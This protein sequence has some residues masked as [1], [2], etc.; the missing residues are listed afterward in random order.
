MRCLLSVVLSTVVV[1]TACAPRATVSPLSDSAESRAIDVAQGPNCPRDSID[2]SE[3]TLYEE[4]GFTVRLPTEYRRSEGASIDSKGATWRARGKQVSY[5]YGFYS[6]P[7]T[8][9]YAQSFPSMVICHEEGSRTH[10]RVIAFHVRGRSYLPAPEGSYGLAGHWPRLRESQFGNVSLTFV[11][12]VEKP[13]DRA[14]LL[15]IL[16]TVT[17]KP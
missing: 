1:A 15:A 3:W 8:A 6:N 4:G 2:A 7:L 10:P 17:F 9:E 5:D 13:E 11:G 14:E 16:R 12:A